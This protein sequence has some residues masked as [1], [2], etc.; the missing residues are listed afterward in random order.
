MPLEP[1][2]LAA[3]PPSSPRCDYQ[4]ELVESP[5]ACSG[6][7]KIRLFISP[8]LGLKGRGRSQTVN[9]QLLNLDSCHSIEVSSEE[10]GCGGLGAA[11]PTD[12]K[13]ATIKTP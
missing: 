13:E 7:I 1:G 12:T 6:E 10:T 5:P 3:P 2:L 4:K 9:C 11:K 8:I